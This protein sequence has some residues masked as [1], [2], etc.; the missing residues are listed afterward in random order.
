L[1]TVGLPAVSEGNIILID[2]LRIGV[3]E[4]CSGLGMLMTFFALS[5]AVALMARRPLWER[6]MLIVSAVPIG[7]CINVVRITATGILHRTVGSNVANAVFHDLAGWLMMPLALL[8]LWLEMRY[9][10]RL[11]PTTA[12]AR[13]DPHGQAPQTRAGRQSAP[14]PSRQVPTPILG[15]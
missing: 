13:I 12:P 6:L 15:R 8:L 11:L 1:Q 2:D 7:V 10:A 5:T 4:A 3:V 14:S 9:L